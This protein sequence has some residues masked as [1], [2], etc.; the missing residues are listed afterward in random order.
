MISDMLLKQHEYVSVSLRVPK[1][2]LQWWIIGVPRQFELDWRVALFEDIP[3]DEDKCSTNSNKIHKH[4]QPYKCEYYQ[5]DIFSLD[6][7]VN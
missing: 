2:L 7:D 6:L 5:Q 1:Q 3:I 4:E